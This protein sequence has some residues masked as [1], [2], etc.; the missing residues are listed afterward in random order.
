MFS[1]TTH[2]LNHSY[3]RKVE[4]KKAYPLNGVGFFLFNII[5]VNKYHAL[6]ITNLAPKIVS[7]CLVFTTPGYDNP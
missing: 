6:S 1:I 7:I 5:K 3:Q 2:N 4:N